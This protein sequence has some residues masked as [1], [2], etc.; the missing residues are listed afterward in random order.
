MRAH[1]L[2]YDP[3]TDLLITLR[4][5]SKEP[6]PIEKISTEANGPQENPPEDAEDLEVSL[7]HV[8]IPEQGWA[9]GGQFDLAGSRISLELRGA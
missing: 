4:W 6:R 3:R 5:S 7:T 1:G 2:L 8:A 9:E